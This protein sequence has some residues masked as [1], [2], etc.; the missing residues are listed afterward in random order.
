[1]RK[2]ALLLIILSLLSPQT[3][4]A[5]GTAEEDHIWRQVLRFGVPIS[6]SF[7][8]GAV[9]V[10]FLDGLV[11]YFGVGLPAQDAE[12]SGSNEEISETSVSR[13][14]DLEN[15][16]RRVQNIFW[17]E[18]YDAFLRNDDESLIYL[19]PYAF[20]TIR[21]PQEAI[22]SLAFLSQLPPQNKHI[23]E[24]ELKLM[25]HWAVDLLVE[26]GLDLSVRTAAI[27]KTVPKHL[28]LSPS[29]DYIEFYEHA[30]VSYLNSPLLDIFEIAKIQDREH[31][32]GRI[33][34]PQ[35]SKDEILGLMGKI[36]VEIIRK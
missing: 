34:P 15:L 30:T 26:S 14:S 1:M 17:L 8:G 12:S 22:D 9:K 5:D 3:C 27:L 16:R 10:I 23:L 24:L 33:S 18:I 21:N 20:D 29:P 6:I 32:T 36:G 4:L 13:P 11:G 35:F 19:T 2:L 25:R 7:N 28:L 31:N